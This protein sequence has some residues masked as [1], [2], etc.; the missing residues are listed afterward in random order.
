MN[1]RFLADLS[2]RLGLVFLAGYGSAWQEKGVADFDHLFT[3]TNL[4][5]AVTVTAIAFFALVAA[6]R[7]GNPESAS[8]L[9]PPL[10]PPAPVPDDPDPHAP[11]VLE[12]GDVDALRAAVESFP[13][14]SPAPPP[15]AISDPK[16]PAWSPV[17]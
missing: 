9:P 3:L 12:P 13:P 8:V 2:E 10:Q 11:Q 17:P 7:V 5:A 15:A 4:K 14:P 6:K 16:P 1:K